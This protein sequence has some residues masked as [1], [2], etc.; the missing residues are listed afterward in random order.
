MPTRALHVIFT[1]HIPGYLVLQFYGVI[2]FL[3]SLSFQVQLLCAD[4]QLLMSMSADCPEEMM[5]KS[6][7]A[8]AQ[9]QLTLPT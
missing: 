3:H 4:S 9:G 7:H 8:E 2:L 5:E 1:L 6:G